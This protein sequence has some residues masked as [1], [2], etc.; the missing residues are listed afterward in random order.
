MQICKSEKVEEDRA[1]NDGTEIRD[2]NCYEAVQGVASVIQ[3]GD[4][5][6]PSKGSLTLVDQLQLA[7]QITLGMVRVCMSLGLPAWSSG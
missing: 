3:M 2:G 6:S 4:K 1:I 5:T 7:R